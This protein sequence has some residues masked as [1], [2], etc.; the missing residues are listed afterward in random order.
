[1]RWSVQHLTDILCSPGVLL[2]FY[3]KQSTYL[4]MM[5]ASLVSEFLPQIILVILYNIPCFSLL[6]ACSAS[7]T[8]FSTDARLSAF[9]EVVVFLSFSISLL[10]VEKMRQQ[11]YK[12]FFINH[13][14]FWY[15]P[16]YQ[17]FCL[18]RVWIY[19][20]HWSNFIDSLEFLQFSQ[21]TRRI[22]FP[23]FASLLIFFNWSMKC[24]L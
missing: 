19:E 14:I 24:Q 7:V 21:G 20:N 15:F 4:S 17:F 2:C 13:C 23:C 10:V 12:D 8:K 9:A 22:A 18:R 5:G 1:M 3:S 6:A 16:L 11:G